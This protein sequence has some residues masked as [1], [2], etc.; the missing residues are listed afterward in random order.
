MK[1]PN[2]QRPKWWPQ[3]NVISFDMVCHVQSEDTNFVIYD[4]TVQNI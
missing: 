2:G 4:K 3:V 1:I